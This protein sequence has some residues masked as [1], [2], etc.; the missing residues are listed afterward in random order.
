[1]NRKSCPFC[2]CKET[3]FVDHSISSA[4]G[5]T[6]FKQVLCHGCDARGGNGIDESEATEIWNKR[7]KEGK[8]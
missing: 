1:M 5:T 8:T 6:V 4:F 7:E 3:S 2:G